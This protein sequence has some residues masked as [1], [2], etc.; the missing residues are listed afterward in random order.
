MKTTESLP[1]A[2]FAIAESDEGK[3]GVDSGGKR[4][5]REEW[6]RHLEALHV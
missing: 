4:K 5:R 1:V 2:V 3:N 6:A